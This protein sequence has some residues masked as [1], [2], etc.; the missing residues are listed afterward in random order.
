[1]T[2][3]NRT[4]ESQEVWMIAEGER[5]RRW[6][7]FGWESRFCMEERTGERRGA[8]TGYGDRFVGIMGLK[9]SMG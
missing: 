2:D 7:R 3:D 8:N 9:G 6:V 4:S 5:G 1:M